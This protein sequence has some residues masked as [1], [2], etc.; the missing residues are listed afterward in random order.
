[1]RAVTN[2]L[3]IACALIGSA[4]RLGGTTLVVR[5]EKDRIILASD[6]R[7]GSLHPGPLIP[8]QMHHDDGCKEL[9]LGSVGF[10]ASGMLDY[11]KNVPT[12][13]V[14]DWSA[15]SDAIESHRKYGDDLRL[16]AKDWERQSIL[17]YELFYRFDPE[18]VKQLASV[19][20]DNVLEVAFFAGWDKRDPVLIMVSVYIDVNAPEVFRAREQV[21]PARDLPYTSSALTQELI[22]GNTP[23]TLAVA[24]AWKALSATLP[25]DEVDWRQT[26]FYIKSTAD[27]DTSV[28]QIANII[29]IPV[30]GQATWLRNKTCSPLQTKQ[31]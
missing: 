31:K 13:L 12:D 3:L 5:L 30:G 16:M 25:R 7:L 4:S 21:L 22:E 26:E 11:K 17:H 8:Q 23:R 1:M 6:T 20:S 14:Q 10:A 28:S 18:R 27:Y 29:S 2:A 9:A 24:T 19:N 15:F